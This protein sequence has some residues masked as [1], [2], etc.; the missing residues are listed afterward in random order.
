MR[1]LELHPDDPQ[2]RLLR[3]A[4]D[5][6]RQGAVAAL[7]TDACYVLACRLDD[8][9]AVERLRAIRGIDERH[10]LTL[11]CRDLAEIATYA[12]VD[13]RQYRFLKA[14]TPGAYTFVLPATKE[15]PRR[16]WHPSRKTLGMRVPDAPVARGLMEALG[17]PLIASTLTLHG[18]DA[19]LADPDEIVDRIG[20][21]LDL[22]LDIGPVGTRPTTIIDLTAEEPTVTRIGCGEVGHLL[23]RET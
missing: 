11:L 17:E 14:H 15:V 4:A 2:P 23:V 1:R 10:L 5:A 13:N 6:L 9:A 20:G 22:L 16:L 7:P 8:K 12:N 21:Q 3:Q 19:P 18:D